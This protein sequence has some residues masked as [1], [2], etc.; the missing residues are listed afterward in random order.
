[1]TKVAALP[2]VRKTAAMLEIERKHD[3]KDIRLIL[4][5]LY[6]KYGSQVQA[7]EALKLDQATVSIWA[8]RL[9]L[10]FTSRPVAVITPAPEA[11]AN[12]KQA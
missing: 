8:V 7:A 10:S 6:E 11:A 5:D 9:G 12:G 4:K 2:Y 1:M 3:G